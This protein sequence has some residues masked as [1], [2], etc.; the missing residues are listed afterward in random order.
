MSRTFDS[1]DDALTTCIGRQPIFFVATAP[2]DPD[3]H[4]NLSPKGA[5]GTF[6]ILSPTRVAYLDL[7][8]SGIETIAHLRENGRI[9]LMFCAFNGPPKVLR[10]HGKGCVIQPGDPGFDD[11]VAAFTPS[12]DILALLRAVIVI[13]ITRISDSCGFVV[14]RME[15]IEERDQLFRHGEQKALKQGPDWK[16]TYIQVNN[17]QSIDGL[18]GIDLPDDAPELTAEEQKQFSSSGKAL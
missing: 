16:Q 12:D 15:L 1:L 10:L 6:R 13:D 17:H 11:L 5:M 3:G 18:S 2:N 8:G 14:P 7:T 4:V 9:V